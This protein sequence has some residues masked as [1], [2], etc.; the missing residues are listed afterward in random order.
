MA[1]NPRCVV[2]TNVLISALLSAEGVPNRVVDTVLHHGG[3]LLSTD[4]FEELEETL[5]RP[6]FD[7]YLRT[8][9]REGY[10]ALIQGASQFV[11]VTDHVEECRDPDD[12]KFLELAVNGNA[13]VI[14]SGDADLRVMNSFRGIPV[15]S[16]DEFLESEFVEKRG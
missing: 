10:L 2:D 4:V 1:S 6:K 14:I 12:D 7:T 16:P 13:D 15:L 5:H 3:L 11:E 9:D 8:E